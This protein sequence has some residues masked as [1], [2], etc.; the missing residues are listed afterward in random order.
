MQEEYV[1]KG[2]LRKEMIPES[3]YQERNLPEK[4]KTR[5]KIYWTEAV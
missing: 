3:S 2:R 5:W 1:T 4:E